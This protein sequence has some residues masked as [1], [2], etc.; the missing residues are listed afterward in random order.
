MNTTTAHFNTTGM[1][2]G[3]CSMLIEL[4][5][6]KEPGIESVKADYAKGTTDVVY[7]PDVITADA[8]SAK[9]GDL[10]YTAVLAP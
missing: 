3:S 7:D 5:I 4:T 9:I 2:C 6:K 8:I 10:G 1:H